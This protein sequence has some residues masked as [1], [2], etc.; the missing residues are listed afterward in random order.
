MDASIERLIQELAARSEALLN[1]LGYSRVAVR[2][3]DGYYGWEEHAPYDAI[4]VTCAPDHIPRPLVA[5]YS[6]RCWVRWRLR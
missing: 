1:Q 6:M 2:H 5:H 4:I 3:A